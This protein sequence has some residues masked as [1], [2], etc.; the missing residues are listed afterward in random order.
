MTNEDKQEVIKTAMTAA[1][2]HTAAIAK[3]YMQRSRTI[4]EQIETTIAI[5]DHGVQLAKCFSALMLV[6]AMGSEL[7]NNYLEARGINPEM[8]ASGIAKANL[9]GGV[10]GVRT[11]DDG[12]N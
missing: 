7:F 9:G 12:S 6:G 10:P 8:L 4:E 1:E 2:Q 3:L 5:A 11:P